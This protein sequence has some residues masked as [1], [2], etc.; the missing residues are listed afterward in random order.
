MSATIAVP[1]ADLMRHAAKDAGFVV[2]SCPDDGGFAGWRSDALLLVSV[3]GEFALYR[4]SPLEELARGKGFG[5]LCRVLENINRPVV[6]E[7][8]TP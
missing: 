2:R 7:K 3:A 8:V 1:V 6:R 4:M 5:P